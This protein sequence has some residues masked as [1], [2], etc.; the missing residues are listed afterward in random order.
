VNDLYREIGRL[1]TQ[2]NC[3]QRAPEKNLAAE[4]VPAL[5]DEQFRR[6]NL[7]ATASA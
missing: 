4:P 2:V 7:L 3:A 6:D 5:S 1:T